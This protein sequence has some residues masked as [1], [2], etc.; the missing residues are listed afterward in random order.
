MSPTPTG[1]A[2]N[3]PPKNAA[4]THLPYLYPPI[5]TQLTKQQQFLSCVAVKPYGIMG[6]QKQST[7]QVLEVTQEPG[8]HE[9]V[10]DPADIRVLRVNPAKAEGLSGAIYPWLGTAMGHGAPAAVL[11]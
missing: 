6:R 8:P 7:G 3:H 11:A 1:G 4:P 2:P 10:A 5:A 9:A